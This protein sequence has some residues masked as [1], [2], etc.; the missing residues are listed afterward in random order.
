LVRCEVIDGRMAGVATVRRSFVF[1][2]KVR[3]RAYKE[4]HNGEGTSPI[5]PSTE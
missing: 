3:E 2:R 4:I 5:S 1:V